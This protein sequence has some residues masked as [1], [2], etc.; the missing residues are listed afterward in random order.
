M[1]DVHDH[2][3]GKECRLT[4][5]GLSGEVGRNPG[6][7]DREEQGQ[8]YGFH[9]SRGKMNVKIRRYR[10]A[11]TERKIG[12]SRSFELRVKIVEAD[13]RG[14]QDVTFHRTRE[15]WHNCNESEP[16]ATK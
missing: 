10:S 3:L 12:G 1:P 7:Q 8:M 4:G 5:I 13:D 16:N 9:W 2:R 6:D 14:C 11:L 15:A